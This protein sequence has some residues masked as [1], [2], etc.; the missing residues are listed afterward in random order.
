MTKP[1]V[2]VITPVYNA[3]RYINETVESVIGQEYDGEIQHIIIDDGSTDNPEYRYKDMDE[4]EIYRHSQNYGEHVS[5]NHGM[6]MVEGKYFMIVNADDPLLPSAI[7]KLVEFM[8]AHPEVLCAYPDYDVIDSDGK[9]CWHVN[10]R[11]YDFSWMV[12]YHTWLPSVGSIFRSSVIKDVG[13]RVAKYRWLGDAEYW[14][15]VGLAGPMAHVP[16]TLACW[17]NHAGQLSRD[18]HVERARDHIRLM[19]NFYRR[20]DLPVEIWRARYQAM[21]WAY[22]VAAAVSGDKRIMAKYAKE[23]LSYYPFLVLDIKFWKQFIRRAWFIL[24]R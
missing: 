24:R 10:S 23:A 1:M 16:Y 13:L 14:L 3:A 20:G 18:K 6:R 9:V 7:D 21:C 17:R 5:V 12:R 8:E 2:S 19:R 11:E 22:L 15:R 4:V